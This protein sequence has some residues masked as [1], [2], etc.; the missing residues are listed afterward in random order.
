M[1]HPDDA[2]TLRAQRLARAPLTSAG[3]RGWMRLSPAEREARRADE[4]ALWGG[5]DTRPRPYTL[6]EEIERAAWRRARGM[7]CT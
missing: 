1:S 6:E 2:A 5:S 7:R 3:I 4:A